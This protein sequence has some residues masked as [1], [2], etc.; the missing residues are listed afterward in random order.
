MKWYVFGSRLK[1][2]NAGFFQSKNNATPNP[3]LTAGLA[4]NR[5]LIVSISHPNRW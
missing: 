4:A 5:G 1:N 2:P 3:N